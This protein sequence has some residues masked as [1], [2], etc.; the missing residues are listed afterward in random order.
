MEHTL[1]ISRQGPN[2]WQFCNNSQAFWRQVCQTRANTSFW[3]DDM[4]N[5]LDDSDDELYLS[6]EACHSWHLNYLRY[7][8]GKGEIKAIYK[9]FLHYSFENF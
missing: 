1:R 9:L 7:L 8:Q 4:Y 2:D 6:T 5:K 3:E